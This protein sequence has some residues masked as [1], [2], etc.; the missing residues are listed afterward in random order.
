[1]YATPCACA[2]SAD[3]RRWQARQEELD[4]R[5]EA[6]HTEFVRRR[7]AELLA[8]GRFDLFM[9][10]DPIEA[11]EI[12]CRMLDADATTDLREAQV[13]AIALVEDAAERRAEWE[14]GRK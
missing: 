7:K 6:A 8:A 9:E 14:W 5:V 10:G 12:L 2:V 11:A 3:L 13:R 1:M 4:R